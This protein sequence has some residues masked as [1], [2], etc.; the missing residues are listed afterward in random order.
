MVAKCLSASLTDTCGVIPCSQDNVLLGLIRSGWY[1]VGTQLLV[2]IGVFL[3][4]WGWRQK[5]RTNEEAFNVKMLQD[6]ARTPYARDEKPRHHWTG[7]CT[8]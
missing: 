2:L 5:E 6:Q 3:L 7:P 4:G 1:M 8:A